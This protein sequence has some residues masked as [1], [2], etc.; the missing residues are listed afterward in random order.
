MRSA[1]WATKVLAVPLLM[2]GKNIDNND[3]RYA[4]I[5]ARC[6]VSATRRRCQTLQKITDSENGKMQYVR[7][8]EDTSA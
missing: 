7:I 3:A 6:I 8:N 5:W 1:G 4:A 2:A